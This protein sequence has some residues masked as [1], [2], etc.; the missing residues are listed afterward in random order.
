MVAQWRQLAPCA[1]PYG[2]I[3]PREHETGAHNQ[4]R[5]LNAWLGEYLPDRQKKLHELRK[6]SGSEVLTQS[7]NIVAAAAFLRDSIKTT[8]KH[9]ASFLKP[10]AGLSRYEI[11]AVRRNK[12]TA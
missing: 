11:P 10:V 5:C 4:V 7:G 6:H 2:F 9:Y 8:E 12:H 1:D 3:V